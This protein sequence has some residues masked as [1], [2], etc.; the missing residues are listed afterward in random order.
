MKFNEF[1]SYLQKIEDTSSRNEITSILGEV[2]NKVEGEEVAIACYFVTGRIA[3][4]FI[5][6]EFNMSEKIIIKAL[7]SF[8][9]FSNNEINVEN[10]RLDLG[11]VGLVAEE[12]FV[13]CKSVSKMNLLDVFEG[14]WEIVNVSG[15]GSIQKKADLYIN[16]VSKMSSVE[17]K[18]LTRIIVGSLRLGVSSKTIIDSISFAFQGDK[19]YKEIL[20]NSYGIHPDLGLLAYRVLVEKD[21]SLNKD[22]LVLGI[23]IKSRLVER[24]KDYDELSERMG[25]DFYLQ[26]KFDGLRCQAHK[27]VDYKSDFFSKTVWNKYLKQEKQQEFSMFSQGDDVAENEDIKLFSRSLEDLTEMFPD[28]I[29][30]ISQIKD[31]NLVLDCEIVGWNDDLSVYGKFQDTMKRKRKY[32][33][34]EISKEVPVRLY[35]FDILYK[36]GNSLINTPLSERL[37]ILEKLLD[38]DSFEFIKLAETR[39]V[40]EIK[41]VDEFFIESVEKGLE[42]LIAKK[43]DSIYEPGERNFGWIKLKKSMKKN[44]VDTVDIVIMGYYKGSGRQVSLGIGALL[45]GIVNEKG[46]INTITKIGTGVTDSLWTEILEKLTPL[47]ANKKPNIY[48]NVHK[49]LIPDIWILPKIVAT[50]EADEITRS[51]VHT[52][53]E[54]ILG[55]GLALRFPRLV[56]FG[57]DKNFDE[58]TSS[59][60]LVKM[61][62]LDRDISIIV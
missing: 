19:G 12:I 10:K 51:Q 3:P 7:Q 59:K 62:K 53:C 44:L 61:A 33:I 37:E 58:A 46:E 31:M 27:G 28:I 48:K 39:R 8:A 4:M 24:V 25:D 35:I 36:N 50:V 30:E 38:W 57:R 43:I 17:A 13:M 16:L 56:S 41:E 34:S 2:L 23:P 1:C 21:G 29:K 60:E 9:N 54:D 26:P 32:D 40:S 11:D 55:Y 42:G 18:Y 52:A 20:E 22:N 14:L 49:S 15:N 5:N 45:A 47:E 6:S